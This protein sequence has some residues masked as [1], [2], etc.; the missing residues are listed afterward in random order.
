MGVENKRGRTDL[1]DRFLPLN[2][3]R[4][5]L[6]LDVDDQ[7]AP[8]EVAGDGDGDVDVADGLRPLVWEGILLGLLLGTGRGLFGGG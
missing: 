3:G 7:V 6:L 2:A 4:D 1:E 5:G 8:L